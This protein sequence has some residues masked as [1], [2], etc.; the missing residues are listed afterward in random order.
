MQTLLVMFTLSVLDWKYLFFDKLCPKNHYCLLILKFG[1]YI[2]SNILNLMIT[3]S[4]LDRKYPFWAK[5]A[6]IL[7]NNF[8]RVKLLDVTNTI[9]RNPIMLI[10]CLCDVT[11]IEI[12]KQ[13]AVVNTAF[14]LLPRIIFN[15]KVILKRKLSFLLNMN[16]FFAYKTQ[17]DKSLLNVLCNINQPFA[18]KTTQYNK[19]RLN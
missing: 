13:V 11:V 16:Q 1:N 7:K 3:F 15:L 18:Y 4:L 8:F 2:N 6:H 5:L 17:V 10:F 14:F 9:M 12:F 19:F